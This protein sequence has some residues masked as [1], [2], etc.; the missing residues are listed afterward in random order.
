MPVSIKIVVFAVITAGFVWLS[1]PSLRD[2]KSHG[3]YR[4]FVWELPI[5]MILINLEYW[6][7]KP[8]CLR[9]IISWFLFIISLSAVISGAYSLRKAGKPGPGRGDPQ[10]RGI[11]KTTEL[12][13]KGLYRYIRHP[14]YSSVLYGIWGVFLKRPSVIGI[15]LAILTCVFMTITARMEEIENIRYFGDEYRDYMTQTKMF[16]PYL[17]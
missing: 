13:T 14:M 15:C 9:Q 4:F 1:W 6:F 5:I 8:F 12:V 3:F 2:F 10:L 11:E 7:D 17:F 16:I